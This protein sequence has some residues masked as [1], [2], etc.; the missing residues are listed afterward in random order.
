MQIGICY[1]RTE[2]TKVCVFH[3]IL[4]FINS[5]DYIWNLQSNPYINCDHLYHRGQCY[6]P[7]ETDLSNTHT[8][9]P[10]H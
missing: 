1:K 7:V 2:G 6:F 8:Q 4:S 10:P 9:I 5:Q 3:L